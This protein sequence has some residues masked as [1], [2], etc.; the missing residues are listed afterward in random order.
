MQDAKESR[1]GS[2]DVHNKRAYTPPLFPLLIL[3]TLRPHLL[4]FSFLRKLFDLLHR[5][6]ARLEGP[7]VHGVRGMG[8]GMEEGGVGVFGR[9]EKVSELM[10]F[11][12]AIPYFLASSCFVSWP[13][14]C[15]GWLGS[16]L[17]C[18]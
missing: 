9:L 8:R 15:R 17:A 7:G 12:I 10:S 14:G 3:F 13:Y 5:L 1:R 11:A 16:D 2:R 6:V 4:F 18:D